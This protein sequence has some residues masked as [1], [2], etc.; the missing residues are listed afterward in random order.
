MHITVLFA[1]WALNLCD[2]L[3]PSPIATLIASLDGL[4][5][6]SSHSLSKGYKP[7]KGVSIAQP[8]KW[9]QTFKYTSLNFGPEKPSWSPNLAT[10]W[11]LGVTHLRLCPKIKCFF[12]TWIIAIDLLVCLWSSYLHWGGVTLRVCTRWKNEDN[13][14]PF[15]GFPGWCLYNIALSIYWHAAMSKVMWVEQRTGSKIAFDAPKTD[16]NLWWLRA[17]VGQVSQRFCRRQEKVAVRS[18]HWAC[19]RWNPLWL[20][21]FDQAFHVSNTAISKHYHNMQLLHV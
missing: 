11:Q 16:S 21:S 14:H 5:C 8:N 12:C 2:L 3:V 9:H 17:G 18:S 4:L 13:W 19:R 15:T 7:A 10:S 1:F 6:N 20:W